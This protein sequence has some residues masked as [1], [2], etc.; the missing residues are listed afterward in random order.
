VNFDADSYGPG[1]IGRNSSTSL[2]DFS[3]VGGAA[4]A[5]EKSLSKLTPQQIAQMQPNI[6]Q[7]L[8]DV[9]GEMDLQDSLK[10]S[11]QQC[12]LF[13]R[14]TTLIFMKY[15]RPSEKS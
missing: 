8:D 7:L 5:D 12:K 9:G 2:Q 6:D 13:I 10:Q 4:R 15:F 14:V 11:L 1:A 3:T